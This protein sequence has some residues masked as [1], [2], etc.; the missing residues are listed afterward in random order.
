MINSY[1]ESK[2]ETNID[3]I[4]KKFEEKNMESQ[5]LVLGHRFVFIF[6]D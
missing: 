4:M 3:L 1:F 6:Y 2:E 5:C